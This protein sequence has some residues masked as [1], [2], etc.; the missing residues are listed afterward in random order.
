MTLLQLRTMLRRRLQEVTASQWTDATLNLNLNQ[1]LR[2]MQTKIIK[3][4]P[5]AFIY[6]DLQDSIE[7][8]SDYPVPAGTL[9][10]VQIYKLVSGDYVSL[11]QIPMTY[12]R[13]NENTDYSNPY[14]AGFGMRGRYIVVHPTP[15]VAT[16]DFLKIEYVPWLTMGADSDVPE[17]SLGLHDGIVYR[18]E[19]ISLGDTAQEAVRAKEDLGTVIDDIHLYYKRYQ[20]R[21]HIVLDDV[22]GFEVQ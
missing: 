15:T 14:D 10:V 11:D 13:R 4:D 2:F 16:V 17:L 1:G 22:T 8:E 6:T 19:M 5:E 3:I 18:A 21:E 9:S 20:G 12:L 7:N